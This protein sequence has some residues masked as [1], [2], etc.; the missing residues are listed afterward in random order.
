MIGLVW[1]LDLDWG[2]EIGI[3]DRDFGFGL[4]FGIGD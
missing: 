2:L 1:I 3:G 4:V